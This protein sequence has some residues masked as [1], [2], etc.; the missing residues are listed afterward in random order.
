MNSIFKNQKA[1]STGYTWIFGLVTLFGLGIL[2]I[3]FN[4]V[5]TAHLLPII[6]E[7]VNTSNIDNATKNQIY[8]ANDKYMTFFHILPFV[9]F[10][11]VIIYMLM[12]AW[13]K[14]QTEL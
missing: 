7:Q 11:V 8:A 10:F 2:Y 5:F 12:A 1:F 3:V 4:Q 9:L 13:R 6:T 14:E